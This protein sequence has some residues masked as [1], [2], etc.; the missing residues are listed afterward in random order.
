MLGW[1]SASASIFW[2]RTNGNRNPSLGNSDRLLHSQPLDLGRFLVHSPKTEHH[3]NRGERSVPIFR[4]LRPYLEDVFEQAEP[5]TVYVINRYRNAKV[6]LRTQ[7]LRIIAKAG[8]TPSA[9]QSG[10]GVGIFLPVARSLL[11]D[12][13][14]VC[15]CGWPLPTGHQRGL[16]EGSRFRRCKKRCKCAAKSDVARKGFKPP[17]VA[18]RGYH[19]TRWRL[20]AR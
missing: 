11:M 9:G 18:N 16:R 4:E 10:N 19:R 2:E 12:R 7:L 3:E 6:N 5:G 1:K 15:R 13:Q 14:Y 17:G 20:L 8:L